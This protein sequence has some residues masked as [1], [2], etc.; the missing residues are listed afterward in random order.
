VHFVKTNYLIFGV[1]DKK[2]N[3]ETKRAGYF[4]VYFEKGLLC[5]NKLFNFW[6]VG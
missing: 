2:R 1:W 5:Q 6:G 3:K 4:K